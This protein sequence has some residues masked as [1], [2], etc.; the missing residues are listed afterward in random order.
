MRGR[1]ASVLRVGVRGGLRLNSAGRWAHYSSQWQTPI[2]SIETWYF[3]D[4]AKQKDLLDFLTSLGFK[5][6]EDSIIWPG[7]P[8]TI[9]LFWYEPEDFKFVSGVDAS[10]F[11]LDDNAREVWQTSSEWGIRTR[12]SIWASSFDKE[13][14]NF[15]MRDARRQFGGKFKNDYYGTNRYTVIEKRLSTP[16]GRG[17]YA[18]LSRI[19]SDLDQLKKVIPA[20]NIQVVATPSEPYTRM[21][22]PKGVWK[23]TSQFDPSRVLYN[24]LIPFVVASLEHFFSQTFQIMLKYDQQARKKLQESSRKLSVADAM[25]VESGER[26]LE[27]FVSDWYSFQNIDSINSAFHDFFGIDFWRIL[28]KRRKV[29]DKLPLLSEALQNLIEFRHGII[30]RFNIDRTVDRSKVIE[31]ID[32]AEVI[33]NLF[34]EEIEKKTGIEIAPG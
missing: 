29:R 24:A 26:S 30:H 23:F 16:A 11:P 2:M 18:T 1:R 33:V 9:H 17:I 27:S 8:G 19:T 7:P 28:R 3:P 12:T 6:T 20:E 14:Q 25:Q 22:D 10:L 32:L 21:N 5:Q 34:A 31:L 13:F 4:N 15:V